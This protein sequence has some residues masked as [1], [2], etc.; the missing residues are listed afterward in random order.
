[1]RV[2][3]ISDTHDKVRRT[4]S[5]VELLVAEGAEAL[6]HC[7]DVT[8]PDVVHVCGVLPS[9]FVLGNN[10][11]VD[12]PALRQA[13]DEV[14]GVFLGWGGEVT[15]A[16]KRLAVTHGHLTREVHRLAHTQPDYLLFGHSHQPS[17]RREGS[18]RWINPGALQRARNYTVALLELETDVLKFLTVPH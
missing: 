7:G 15:L 17:D 18:T 2:G 4:N 1:M 8:G 6:I 14:K 11:W 12:D 16:G 13:I 9:T 5:A 10:D 3:I